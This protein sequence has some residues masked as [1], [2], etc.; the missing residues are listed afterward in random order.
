MTGCSIKGSGKMLDQLSDRDHIISHCPSNIKRYVSELLTEGVTII[1]QYL[2]LSLCD[3]V[4]EGF[5]AFARTN[6]EIFV[7][8]EDEHGYSGRCPSPGK[9]GS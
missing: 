4:R 2:P 6:A 8:N 3:D 9:T 7:P 5:T 1:S